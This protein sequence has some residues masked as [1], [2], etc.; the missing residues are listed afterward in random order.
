MGK[1]VLQ[2]VAKGLLGRFLA[3]GALILGLW[4]L[5]RAFQIGNLTAGVPL[6]L[7]GG[8]VI[9]AGMYLMVTGRRGEPPIA[10]SAPGN[11]EDG[12]GDPINGSNQG[13]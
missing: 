1:S 11:E 2:S 3:Y 4:L 7:A 5:Y 9:L 6:G 10:P 8:A 13:A 12:K